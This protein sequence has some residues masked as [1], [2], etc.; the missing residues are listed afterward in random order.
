MQIMMPERSVVDQHH[1][2]IPG[3]QHDAVPAQRVMTDGFAGKSGDN[4]V[5]PVT[6]SAEF[7]RMLSGLIMAASTF[8]RSQ[9]GTAAA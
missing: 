9:A 6:F 4:G 8:V 3:Q 2:A 1:L 5:D 7:Y